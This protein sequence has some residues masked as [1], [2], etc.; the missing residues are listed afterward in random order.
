MA[1]RVVCR[2][3]L[4]LA[5]LGAW[6]PGCAYLAAADTAK[7]GIVLLKSATREEA[8]PAKEPAVRPVAAATETRPVI[9]RWD[10][11][12]Q[13]LAGTI[14]MTGATDRSG[15]VAFATP[16]GEPACRGTLQFAGT[17]SGTWTVGCTNGHAAS[18]TLAPIVAGSPSLGEGTDSRGR[19]LRLTVGAR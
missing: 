5:V 14:A 3:M 17:A 1:M 18:G 11:V 9:V 4:C 16:G 2:R 19:E 15:A 6:A 13:P 10:G 12:V 7:S 8:V